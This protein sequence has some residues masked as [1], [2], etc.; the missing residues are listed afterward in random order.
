MSVAGQP[1][2]MTRLFKR[3]GREVVSMITLERFTVGDHCRQSLVGKV[4]NAEYRIHRLIVFVRRRPQ[5]AFDIRPSE[6]V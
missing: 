1:K 5:S 2:V 6:R 3:S 4:V